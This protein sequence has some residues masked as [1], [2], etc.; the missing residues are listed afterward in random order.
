MVRQ[1]ESQLLAQRCCHSRRGQPLALADMV[2]HDENQVPMLAQR[3]ICLGIDE[4][5]GLPVPLSTKMTN[6]IGMRPVVECDRAHCTWR[7]VVGQMLPASI[8]ADGRMV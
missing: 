4:T 1:F 2:F 6:L 8:I 3:C 5:H 7:W